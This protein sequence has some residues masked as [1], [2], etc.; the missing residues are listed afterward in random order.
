VSFKD[1]FQTKRPISNNILYIVSFGELSDRFQK[2]SEYQ[3]FVFHRIVQHKNRGFDHPHKFFY[4]NGHYKEGEKLYE[5]GFRSFQYV[6]ITF[7]KCYSVVYILHLFLIGTSL[8][9]SLL[10]FNVNSTHG[11]ENKF[12]NIVPLKSRPPC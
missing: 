10:N 1:N 9:Y 4:E 8:S 2:T 7:S 11:D 12:P 3:K 5:K 6:N